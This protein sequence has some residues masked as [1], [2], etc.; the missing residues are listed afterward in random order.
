MYREFSA[1][2]FVDI[3]KKKNNTTRLIGPPPIP[4]K[5]DIIPR[6][7]PIRTHTIAFSTL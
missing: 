3:E 2:I 1:A 4:R 6:N 7:T 5:E